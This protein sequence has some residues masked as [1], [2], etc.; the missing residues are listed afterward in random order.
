MTEEEKGELKPVKVTGVALQ[1][2]IFSVWA[3]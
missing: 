2:N 3:T 1:L